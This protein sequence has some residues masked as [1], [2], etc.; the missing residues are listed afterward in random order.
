MQAATFTDEKRTNKTHES[1]NDPE[2]RS[3][4]RSPTVRKRSWSYLGHTVVENRNGSDRGR[5]G[6]PGQMARR[7]ARL[8]QAVLMVAGILKKRPRSG[9]I[10]LG[11]DKAYDTRDFVDTVRGTWE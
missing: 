3:K 7:N 6:N 10:T 5:H 1:K 2:A 11:A 9:R 8:A 4:W